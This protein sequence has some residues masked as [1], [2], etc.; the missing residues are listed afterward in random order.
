M[1]AQINVKAHN[2]APPFLRNVSLLGRLGGCT[3]NMSVFCSMPDVGTR[4]MD[5]TKHEAEHAGVH[6]I[7][8]V[9]IGLGSH[10]PGRRQQDLPPFERVVR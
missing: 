7:E 10:Y 2:G 6:H 5:A 3:S 8:R 1:V 9:Q 4:G